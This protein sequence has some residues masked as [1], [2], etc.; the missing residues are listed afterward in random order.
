MACRV[1]ALVVGSTSAVHDVGFDAGFSPE[2]RMLRGLDVVVAH[3]SSE[4]GWVPGGPD[5]TAPIPRRPF[6]TVGTDGR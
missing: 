1:G 2:P 6:L 4:P 3:L 5:A